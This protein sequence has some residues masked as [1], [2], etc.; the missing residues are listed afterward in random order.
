MAHFLTFFA[1]VAVAQ[2]P[3]SK[4]AL[5]RECKGVAPATIGAVRTAAETTAK[6]GALPG[7]VTAAARDAAK[8]LAIPDSC[9][10]EVARFA[11]ADHGTD[12]RPRNA[13]GKIVSKAE[14][15]RIAAWDALT[16]AEREWRLWQLRNPGAKA[17]LTWHSIGV[18]ARGFVDCEMTTLGIM[19]ENELLVDCKGGVIEGGGSSITGTAARYSGSKSYIKIG[20]SKGLWL[21]GVKDAG[22][23]TGQSFSLAK[24]VRVTGTR[25]YETQFGA[26]RTVFVA[27]VLDIDIGKLAGITPPQ[28]V[29]DEL[30]KG[31]K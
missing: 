14:A 2:I 19:A 24:P 8:S 30:K 26:I 22:A 6:T 15:E 5:E 10:V 21:V 28:T 16:D 27:E 17:S 25:N 11:F 29:L 1:V 3:P 13:K 12:R 9:V 20:D 31:E 18:G 23:T 7:S 4:A